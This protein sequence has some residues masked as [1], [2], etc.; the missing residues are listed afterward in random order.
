VENEIKQEVH[1]I[2]LQEQLQLIHTVKVYMKEYFLPDAQLDPNWVSGYAMKSQISVSYG[3]EPLY[4][5]ELEVFYQ[6]KGSL[7]RK[8]VYL[9]SLVRFS[10]DP[11]LVFH[12]KEQA[13]KVE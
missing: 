4:K 3:D 8:R 1:G 5:C 2:E 6:E 9:V 12:V 11:W 10:N 7:K 13:L